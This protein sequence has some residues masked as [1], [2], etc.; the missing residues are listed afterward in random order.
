MLVKSV[1]NRVLFFLV[2]G[3]VGGVVVFFFCGGGGGGGG[4][5]SNAKGLVYQGGPGLCDY[6]RPENLKSRCS[7]LLYCHVNS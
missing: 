2:V 7:S 6:S 5:N 4:A 3:V 1:F